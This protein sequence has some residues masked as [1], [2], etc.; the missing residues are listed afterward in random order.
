MR[1]FSLITKCRY[2]GFID[3]LDSFF[4]RYLDILLSDNFRER[5]AEVRIEGHTDSR[6]EY[7]YNVR[8]SQSRTSNV[9]DYVVYKENSEY[10]NANE[11]DQVNEILVH[12]YRIFLWKNYG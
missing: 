12:D 10:Q 9:L 2:Q 8:L 4:P 3:I 11:M 6:G 7:M 1:R 5:I